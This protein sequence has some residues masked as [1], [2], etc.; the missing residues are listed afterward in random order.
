MSIGAGRHSRSGSSSPPSAPSARHW[1]PAATGGIRF[2]GEE[3]DSAAEETEP[4][5]G[6]RRAREVQAG[7]AG[8]KANAQHDDLLEF[9]RK[10]SV[11]VLD[12]QGERLG[13]EAVTGIAVS[14]QGEGHLREE[15]DEDGKD[16]EGEEDSIQQVENLVSRSS[17]RRDD[18]GSSPSHIQPPSRAAFR[19]ESVHQSGLPSAGKQ[20]RHRDGALGSRARGGEGGASAGSA[21]SG[22]DPHARRATEPQGG[23]SRP[24]ETAKA[25]AMLGF[26]ASQ[27]SQRPA[28]SDVSGHQDLETRSRGASMAS[29]RRGSRHAVWTACAVHTSSTSSEYSIMHD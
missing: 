29:K 10:M 8:V 27:V 1:P 11:A 17:M 14:A 20:I 4:E 12:N 22:Q 6:E 9:A 25:T 23:T 15:E 2:F 3:E 16:G 18:A 26:A 13:A 28:R 5:D 24:R 7:D 19:P 21:M